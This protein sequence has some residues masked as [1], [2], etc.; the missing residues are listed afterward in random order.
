M[1]RSEIA[2]VAYELWLNNGCPTGSDQEDWFRAEAMVKNALVARCEDPSERPSV[3]R[4]DSRIES[5]IVFELRWEG[6]WE[7]WES[8]WGGARWIW[9]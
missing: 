5:E 7:V 1:L 9:D 3:P 2:A 8:E 6:H 4:S